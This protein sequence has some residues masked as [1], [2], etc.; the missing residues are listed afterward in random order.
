M[1]QKEYKK[2]LERIREMIKE[3]LSPKL[4]KITALHVFEWLQYKNRIAAPF[5]L[6]VKKIF[7][8]EFKN[9]PLKIKKMLLI[10]YL[11]INPNLSDLLRGASRFDLFLGFRK[12]GSHWIPVL[13]MRTTA[14]TFEKYEINLARTSLKE[15]P[16]DEETLNNI[17]YM[18]HI[19]FN[20][21]D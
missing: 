12:H 18:D 19:I 10:S 13:C 6:D 4:I 5:S 3:L 17:D 21:I 16:T 2:E 9:F 11:T 20:S 8:R 15:I 14:G 7:L 1:K